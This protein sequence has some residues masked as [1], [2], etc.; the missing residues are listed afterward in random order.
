LR[1]S[2]APGLRASITFAPRQGRRNEE[3][4]MGSTYKIIL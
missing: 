4:K 3:A 2:A 1:A